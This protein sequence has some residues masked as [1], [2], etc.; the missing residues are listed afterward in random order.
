MNGTIAIVEEV[1]TSTTDI[2]QRHSLSLTITGC[3]S[4]TYVWKKGRKIL[5]TASTITTY[6]NN[7][8]KVIVGCNDNC[9][10]K[11]EVIQ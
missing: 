9:Y 3:T 1:I 8:I 6:G 2:C 10:Y 11:T 7:I 4:P 5:G